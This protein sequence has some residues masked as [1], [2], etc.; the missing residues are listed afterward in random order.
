M[1]IEISLVNGKWVVNGKNYK[2]LTLIERDFFDRFLF[3]ERF[4]IHNSK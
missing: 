4:K 1:K 2:D 3:E